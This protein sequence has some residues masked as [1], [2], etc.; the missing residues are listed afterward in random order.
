ME[1]SGIGSAGCVVQ[2]DVHGELG[3]AVRWVVLGV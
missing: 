2:V 3:E 1:G